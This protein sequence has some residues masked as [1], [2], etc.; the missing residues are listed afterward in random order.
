MAL[1]F[2][3]GAQPF[4]PIQYIHGFLLGWSSIKLCHISE[5]TAVLLLRSYIHILNA[6][7]D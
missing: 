4:I 1:V 7:D 3:E 6:V 5:A 2:K